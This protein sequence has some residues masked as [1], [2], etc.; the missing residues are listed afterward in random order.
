M[1]RLI[2]SAAATLLLA[3]AACG[4]ADLGEACDTSGSTDECVEDGVCGDRGDGS[5]TCLKLCT[6]KAQCASGEDCNGISGSS[7]KG[8]RTM[9]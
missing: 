6:D 1:R 2:L 8:C 4:G 9:K 7:L 3:L 5:L